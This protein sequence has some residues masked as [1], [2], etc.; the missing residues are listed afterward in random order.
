M[1]HPGYVEDALGILD[2][3][4]LPEVRPI[5]EAVGQLRIR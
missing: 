1:R 5:L 3:P 2:W 4:P